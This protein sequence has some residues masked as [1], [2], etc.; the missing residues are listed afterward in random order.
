MSRRYTSILAFFLTLVLSTQVFAGEGAHGGRTAELRYKIVDVFQVLPDGQHQQLFVSSINDRGEVLGSGSFRVSDDPFVIPRRR[1]FIWRGGRVVTELVSQDAEFPDV[2][3]L[4]INNRSDVVGSL[5]QYNEGYTIRRAVRWEHGRFSYLGRLQPDE[6]TGLSFASSIND[7]G[8]IA[9]STLDNDV[10]LFGI[11]YR[12]FRG[13]SVRIPFDPRLSATTRDINNWGQVIGYSYP[14][15]F[16]PY[17][18]AYG[19]YIA[20]RKGHVHFLESLPGT[21]RMTPVAINDRN[22]VIGSADGHAI[23]WEDG[24]AQDLGTLPGADSTEATA[25]NVFGTVVGRVTYPTQTVAMIWRDGE[26]RDLNDLIPGSGVHLVSASAINNLGWIAA[27]GQD[28]T[29]PPEAP[30]HTYLLIPVWKYRH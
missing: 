16:N 4:K 11:P 21:D 15:D 9:W 29:Q 1:V 17:D 7:W 28:L 22:Q 30:E 18:G 25:I 3:M 6:D 14:A 13:H 8:E 27:T 19:G 24:A 23:L 2:E 20:D 26:M 5:V 12:W 10:S